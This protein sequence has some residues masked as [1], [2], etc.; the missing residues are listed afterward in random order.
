VGWKDR[1]LRLP[2]CGGARNSLVRRPWNSAGPAVASRRKSVR[3]DI[4][5]ASGES[6]FDARSKR[7]R[8]GDHDVRAPGR[9]LARPSP[10]PRNYGT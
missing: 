9:R 1:A 4:V 2:G 10:Q 6:A 3:T 7:S 8:L 5:I